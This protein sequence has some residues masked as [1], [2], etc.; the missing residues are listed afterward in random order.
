MQIT[1][2]DLNLPNLQ[3]T[4]DRRRVALHENNISRHK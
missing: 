4:L 2:I 1:Q 3:S